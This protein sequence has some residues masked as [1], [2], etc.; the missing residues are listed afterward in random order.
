[1]KP[2]LGAMASPFIVEEGLKMGDF[3]P[4]VNQ[5]LL[6]LDLMICV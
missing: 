5:D 1:M 6:V 3:K 2:Q 4:S